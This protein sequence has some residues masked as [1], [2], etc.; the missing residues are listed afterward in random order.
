MF[1]ITQIEVPIVVNG[2]EDKYIIRPLNGEYFSE[3]FSLVDKIKDT[4]KIDT[5]PETIKLL[6][7]LVFQSLK[8]SY[9][10][11]KDED[12]N[13]FTTQHLFKFIEPLVKIN[14]PQN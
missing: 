14:I 6:H 2:K 9:P 13:K 8:D 7:K 11:Q 4:D 5:D 1:E 3:M 10:E 12:L